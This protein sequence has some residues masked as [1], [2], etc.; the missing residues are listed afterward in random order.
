[1]YVCMIYSCNAYMYEHIQSAW[2]SW[3]QH[4]ARDVK[5]HAAQQLSLEHQA[6]LDQAQVFAIVC[7]YV[8]MCVYVCVC[9]RVYVCVRV[10]ARVR[11]CVFACVVCVLCVYYVLCECALFMCV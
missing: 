8:S 6:R 4:A 10:C 11:A 2:M 9:T 7:V 5:A 3:Q 1:M